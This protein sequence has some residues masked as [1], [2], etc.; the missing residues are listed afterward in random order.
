MADPPILWSPPRDVRA[1][2]RVGQY[3]DWLE[4]EHGRR[5]E[6]YDELWRWSTDE[7]GA[8]W[9]SIWEYLGVSSSTPVDSPLADVRMP[10]ARWFPGASLNWAEHALR[11]RHR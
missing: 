10:G 1:T 11:L 6:T 9:Q 8:F 7:L 5:L 2:S 3:L 4:R